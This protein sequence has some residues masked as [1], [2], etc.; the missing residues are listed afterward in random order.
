MSEK[1]ITEKDIESCWP[2]AL[3]YLA[4]ILNGEYALEEARAD[5][6]SLIGSKH[7]PR[8]HE[9]RNPVWDI[10]ELEAARLE[11]ERT[12]TG[13]NPC[14]VPPYLGARRKYHKLLVAH[15]HLTPG[16]ADT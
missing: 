9:S 16:Q 6:R 8:P 13:T 12:H 1:P 15:R 7:D 5:I 4:D 14:L 3:S 11:C 2:R 10:P